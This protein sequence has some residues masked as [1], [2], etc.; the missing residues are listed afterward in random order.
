MQ[1]GNTVDISN[2]LIFFIVTL[3]FGCDRNLEAPSAEHA[4][5]LRNNPLA[6]LLSTLPLPLDNDLNLGGRGGM[7]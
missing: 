7:E 3:S 4:H 2:Y 6:L 1:W 5:H